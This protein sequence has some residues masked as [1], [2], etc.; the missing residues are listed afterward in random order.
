MVERALVTRTRPAGDEHQV[1]TVEGGRRLYRRSPC[2]ACPWRLDQVGAFPPEA[3]LH[4]AETAYDMAEHTF[5]CHEA[6]VEQPMICAGFLLRGADHNLRIRVAVARREVDLDSVH[7]GGHEL[8]D[9]Y[10]SMATANGC[11]PD[12]PRL[13]PCRGTY[14]RGVTDE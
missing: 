11:H 8:H 13:R 5:A 7:D 6:G 12:H 3:F 1:V 14:P 4:S 10:R 9:D 2:A